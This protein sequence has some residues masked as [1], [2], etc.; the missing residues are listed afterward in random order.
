MLTIP[1]SHD[2]QN[3]FQ[4]LPYVLGQGRGKSPPVEKQGSVRRALLLPGAFYGLFLCFL[5][6]LGPKRESG[7]FSLFLGI[8]QILLGMSF[9]HAVTENG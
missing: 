3:C 6:F 7:L 5:V 9:S 4:T 2:D 1:P 8:K